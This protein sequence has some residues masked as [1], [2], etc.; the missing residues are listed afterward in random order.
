MVSSRKNIINETRQKALLI[1]NGINLLDET[2]SFS[3]GDLLKELKAHNSMDVELD[4][5]F[6][7]FPL[8]FD[9]MIYQEK[10][11][12]ISEINRDIKQQIREKIEKQLLDKNGFNEYHT[13]IM[14]LGYNDILTTNY[15]YSL[16]KSVENN[17]D[18]ILLSKNYKCKQSK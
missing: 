15:D 16:Q 14:S 1:G 11:K 6:K 17:F 13:K 12:D 7:P 2:Q 9:E 5:I 8:V 3:W 18:Q 10:N 4:N